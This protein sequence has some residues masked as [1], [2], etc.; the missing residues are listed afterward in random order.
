MS[1]QPSPRSACVLNIYPISSVEVSEGC[2]QLSSKLLSTSKKP[3]TKQD[4]LAHGLS[5]QITGCAPGKSMNF[6][7]NRKRILVARLGD[8][9]PRRTPFGLI[10]AFAERARNRWEEFVTSRESYSLWIFPP[11]HRCVLVPF[12]LSSRCEFVLSS[13]KAQLKT[14]LISPIDVGM[15]VLAA[16]VFSNNRSFGNGQYAISWQRCFSQQSYS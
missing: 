8:P 4:M 7:I 16:G 9:S 5:T 10:R 12:V 3:S 2:S 13:S 1:V 6:T 11:G 15:N 14:K